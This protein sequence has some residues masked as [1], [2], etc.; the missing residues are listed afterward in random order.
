[1][2]NGI[3]IF[4]YNNRDV[5]YARSSLISGFMAKKNLGVPVSIIT[6]DSTIK[7]MQES[8]IYQH[9]EKLFDK[10]I[11]TERP[12]SQNRRNLRNGGL[13]SKSVLFLNDN[14]CK[15]W[16]LTPYDRTLLI[17]SDFLIYSKT[18]SQY[19]EVES[20]IMLSRSM[21]DIIGG[22]RCGY[23]DMFV[24]DTGPKL[25]W[26]T[27]IMFSK[28]KQSKI[29]FE[30]AEYVR[31]NY[32]YFSD[33]YGFTVDQYRNDISFSIAY[34]MLANFADTQEYFLPPI[35]TIQDVDSVQEMDE[36]FIR[37]YIHDS[38]SGS[39]NILCYLN[40]I[41]VHLMNKN[42]IIDNFQKF[43]RLL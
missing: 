20:N 43:E 11:L 40:D 8:N 9:A 33:L 41:D 4:V 14:R 27:T 17:D 12:K 25:F 24:S 36:N 34:H 1:M 16:E 38:N 2:N 32:R 6:D 31:D 19:W 13:E 39:G 21:K 3:L 7:W 29:F 35:L 37:A 15:A 42:S 28:N 22:N 10:I 23:H 30:L 18:L 26:A 5:D